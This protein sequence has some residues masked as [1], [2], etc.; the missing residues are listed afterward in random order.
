MDNFLK[1]NALSLERESLRLGIQVLLISAYS[2][3][4]TEDWRAIVEVGGEIEDKHFVVIWGDN[5]KPS[6]VTN[7][8]V[9]MSLTAGH[10]Y[11]QIQTE[12][13][14]GK[15]QDIRKKDMSII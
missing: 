5:N 11:V 3:A 4:S 2:F 6:F 9:F 15:L 10:S 1:T 13:R 7:E 12:T 14:H 8:K